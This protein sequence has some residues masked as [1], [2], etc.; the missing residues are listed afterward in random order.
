VSTAPKPDP[1]PGEWIS[2]EEFAEVVRLTPLV[3]IDLI[4]RSSDGRILVGRRVNEP[5]KGVFFVPGG[6]ISKN[7]TKAAALQRIS[8]EELGTGFDVSQAKF[9]GAYEHFYPTNRF[10]IPGFG[11]HYI[12]LGFELQTD[13]DPSSLPTDQHSEYALLTPTEILMHREVHE[14]TKGYFRG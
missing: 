10:H 6:R 13:L 3:A 1:K 8:K 9:L 2:R 7:E 14:N 12:T 5:A 11:T 4:V